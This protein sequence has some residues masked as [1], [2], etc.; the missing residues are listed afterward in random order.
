MNIPKDSYAVITGAGKGLGKAFSE[1]LARRGVNVILISLP[2]EELE[3]E[4][5]RLEEKYQIKAE[6]FEADLTS[7]KDIDSLVDWIA[8]T[9]NISILIN[10]AGYGGSGEF[11]TSNL[12]ELDKMILLNV[13]ATTW[14]SHKL[15]PILRKNKDS[16]ILNVSSLASASPFAFKAVYAA[17][18]VYI[19]FLSKG[20]NKE[21]RK[22]GVHV[23]S[24]HPGPMPTN[25]AVAERIKNQTAVGRMGVKSPDYIAKRSLDE[26]FKKTPVIVVGAMNR[27]HWTLM[28]N[29]P[30]RF[31]MYLLSYGMKKEIYR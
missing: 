30:R 17:S 8:P 2:G 14:I 3:A 28:R 1:E 9:H 22:R 16:Y 7:T 5:Q 25:D 18:K 21:F 15:I 10:N 13:R 6:H 19:E 31:V 4:C 12:D 11:D 24:L 26:L 29:L 20:L 27:I 23:S